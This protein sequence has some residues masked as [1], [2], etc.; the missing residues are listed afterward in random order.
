MLLENLPDQPGELVERWL[1]NAHAGSGQVNWNV[2]MLA[3]ADDAGKPSV[4]A[5]LLKDFNPA[6]CSFT[7]FTNYL[8]RKG[9]EIK[10][11]PR[12]AAAMY[13]DAI[14]RQ[15]RF[16]GAVTTVPNE[17]SD[18]YFASRPRES[19]IGAWASEQSQPIK[20]YEA[21]LSKAEHISKQY[22]GEPIPRP[23]HW[24]GYAITADRIELW[25]SK[26]GRIH[27]RVAYVRDAASR[28]TWSMQ[29]LSP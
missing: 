19:Q 3:T 15:I 29:W 27:E 28:N 17:V 8:S 10:A 2:M 9:R 21:L 1:E 12:V 26:P 23:P 13:W 11:N 16:E 7:F 18:A 24:G 4:R 25:H 20:S 14:E 22:G 6:T 5:V